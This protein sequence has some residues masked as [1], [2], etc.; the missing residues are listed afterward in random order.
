MLLAVAV[1]AEVTADATIVATL[2]NDGA[3]P[4]GVWYIFDDGSSRPPALVA[5]LEPGQSSSLSTS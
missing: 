1:L 2:T 4:A 5:E 3:E